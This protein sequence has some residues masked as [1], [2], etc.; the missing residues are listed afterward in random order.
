[1]LGFDRREALA[2]IPVPTL[3][4][5]GSKDA[6]APAATMAKMAERI[7]GSAYRCF[8]GCGHLVMLE[9]ADA[10]TAAIRDFAN[11]LAADRRAA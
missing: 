2:R 7:P 3:L 8:E 5:A 1:M 11:A 10:F 9:R 4:V 6:N